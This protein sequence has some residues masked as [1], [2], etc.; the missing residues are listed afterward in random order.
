[1]TR[2]EALSIA[3]AQAYALALGLSDPPHPRCPLA[4]IYLAAD[5]RRAAAALDRIHMLCDTLSDTDTLSVG[6]VRL[7][8]R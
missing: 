6:D 1:M 7:A 3:D 5:L 2:D 4:M 8:L